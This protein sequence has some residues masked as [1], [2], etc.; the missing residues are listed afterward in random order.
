MKD[1]KQVFIEHENIEVFKSTLIFFD[2]EVQS[3]MKCQ[4]SKLK[5]NENYLLL[6][7][8]INIKNINLEDD[9]MCL[10]R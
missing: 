3:K 9:I 6:K 5:S 1:E 7:I 10:H 2:I 4:I 8:K